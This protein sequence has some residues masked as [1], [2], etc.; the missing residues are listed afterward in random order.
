M[1]E[2]I[3]VPLDG[4]PVAEQA[5]IPATSIARA[6]GAH[7]HL[8]TVLM[9]PLMGLPELPS[10]ASLGTIEADYLEATAA[11]VQAAGV[12]SVSTKLLRV[13][14]TARA[15][16]E[17]RAEVG[18]GLTVMASHGR[19]AVER[20]W[21]GS[22]ADRFVRTSEAPVL[23]V[24]ATPG[25]GATPDLSADVRFDRVLV[26]LDG[27]EFS[28]A[29]LEPAAAL[30]GATD[31]R[32]VLLRIIEPPYAPGAAL[33]PAGFEFPEEQAEALR[34]EAEAELDAV[35]KRLGALGHAVEAVAEFS[36]PIALGILRFAKN[37]KADVIAI[38]THG[39]GGITRALL[40]SVADKVIR[41][42]DSPVLIVR[43]RNK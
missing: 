20:A 17:H 3:L 10:E 4:T 9:P 38:A 34:R 18:A 37:R 29:A 39:R 31:T 16:E 7:L 12:A 15:L 35:A 25:A 1:F 14:N 21:L 11:R 27:S 22:V 40:G 28:E 33:L 23:L 26:P 32:Y 2:R 13:D 41:G 8:A 5:L 6:S 42:A 30:G 19:G 36:A 43:P 24:R